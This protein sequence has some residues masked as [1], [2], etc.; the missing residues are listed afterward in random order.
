MKFSKLTNKARLKSTQLIQPM[1]GIND[2]LWNVDLVVLHQIIT[3]IC[4]TKIFVPISVR[5]N[6]IIRFSGQT[7]QGMRLS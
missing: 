5:Q 4:V 2:N 1:G 6:D 7:G 3:K